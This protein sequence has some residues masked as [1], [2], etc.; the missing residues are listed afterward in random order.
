M[1]ESH[2][3]IA[4]DM[5]NMADFTAV[6]VVAQRTDRNQSWHV[7]RWWRLNKSCKI[8]CRSVDGLL[9]SASPKSRVPK[10][11]K[12]VL[13]ILLCTTVHAYDI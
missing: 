3:K 10:E 4:Y 12:P 1:I 2:I 5:Q 9:F 11:S 6:L 8:S 13:R 7:W